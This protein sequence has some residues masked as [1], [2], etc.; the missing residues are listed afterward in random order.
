MYYKNII[1]DFGNVVGTFQADSIL[2]HF[3]SSKEDFM[4]LSSILFRN[5]QALDAGTID[6]EENA[7]IAISL[8]P[9]RL[10][11]NGRAFFAEWIRY[12]MPLPKT[13]D[14]I[15]EL[16]ERNAGIYLLSNAPTKFA[17]E[18]PNVFEILKLFDGIV[19]SAPLK[20]AKPDPEIYRHLF[21]AFHLEPEDCFFI[22][23]TEKNILAGRALGMDGIVFT[24]DIDAVKKAVGF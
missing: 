6:Y 22:D 10:K 19:F 7:Q 9:D 20:M 4:L 2:K 14:F 24:Q 17:E 1:F 23:D 8:L 16:K 21:A 13:W 5:W 12:V 3:C 15:R 18:A 11:E